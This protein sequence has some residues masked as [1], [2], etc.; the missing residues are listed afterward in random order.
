MITD[1]SLTDADLIREALEPLTRNGL[2]RV[3][4]NG[5]YQNRCRCPFHG[6]EDYNCEVHSAGWLVCYSQCSYKTITDVKS[7]FGIVTSWKPQHP[8]KLP[9]AA[10]AAFEKRQRLAAFHQERREYRE[11]LHEMNLATFLR[12]WEADLVRREKESQ[13]CNTR[14]S[15]KAETVSQKDAH[16]RHTTTTETSHLVA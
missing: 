6:G 4:S 11:W 14:Q 13:S 2:G 3:K 10:L 9:P 12:L 15:P 7:V 5:K 16:H 8:A 1:T